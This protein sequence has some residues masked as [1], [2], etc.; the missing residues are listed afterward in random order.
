MIFSNLINAGRN[1]R[2]NS[3]F[4]KDLENLQKRA[5]QDPENLELQIQI[6]DLMAKMGEKEEAIRTY[7]STSERFVQ[8]NLLTQPSLYTKLSCDRTSRRGRLK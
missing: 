1:F 3:N 6:G 4:K 8:K 7:Q 2:R 5:S